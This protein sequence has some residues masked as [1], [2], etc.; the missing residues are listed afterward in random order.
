LLVCLLC[1][2]LTRLAAANGRFP[3]AQRL[4]Q[5]PGDPAHLVLAGTFGLAITG[6]GGQTWQ[7]V[8]ESAFS[9]PSFILDPLIS[10]SQDRTL[11]TGTSLDLRRSDSSACEFDVVLGEAGVLVP[12]YT[13]DVDGQT[14]LALTSTI[15]EGRDHATIQTSPDGLNWET[16]GAPLEQKSVLTLDV[17]PSDAQRLYVSA[18][19][20]RFDGA[21]VLVGQQGVLLRS[22]DRGASF[23]ELAI[24]GTSFESQPFIAK[25]HPSDP[26]TIYLR[27]SGQFQN[28]LEL[29]IADDVLLISRDAG[30]SWQE[31]IRRSAKL[32]AFTLSPDAETILVGFGPPDDSAIG[33][34]L[35]QYG[36]YRIT[37]VEASVPEVSTD[38]GPPAS[39]PNA[40]DS[41]T[42]GIVVDHFIQNIAGHCLTWLP[43]GLY[44]CLRQFDAGFEVAFTEDPNFTDISELTPLLLLNRVE[45][46]RQCPEES[47]A[48]VCA[49]RWETDCR[50]LFACG[51][52]DFEPPEVSVGGAPAVS[53]S[54]GSDSGRGSPS[55]GEPTARQSSSG[56]TILGSPDSEP[57]KGQLALGFVLGCLSLLLRRGS[58]RKE[59]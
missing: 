19:V 41:G 40:P 14:L 8:C 58:F 28:D 46:P 36:L 24:P 1:L 13:F 57:G 2:G 53:D 38:G 21:G 29:P 42:Q 26:D 55:S 6:D 54:G 37:G 23:E 20:P 25:I 17:A 50:R 43:E 22:E 31:L 7:H 45:G 5:D 30:A 15:V 51:A 32:F 59:S 27:L 11:Y 49:S 39:E 56:C 47:E 9:D 33:A 18:L 16:L 34:D 44:V 35:T 10:F 3:R 52:S 48:A 4:I 12:D